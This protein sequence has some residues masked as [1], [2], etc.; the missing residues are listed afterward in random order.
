MID[1]KTLTEASD[2]IAEAMKESQ[3]AY[4]FSPSS[5]TFMAMQACLAAAKAVDE[6]VAELASMHSAEWL[7]RFPKIIGGDDVNV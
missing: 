6:H 1:S 3:L 2:K 7:R 5:Y 4:Q